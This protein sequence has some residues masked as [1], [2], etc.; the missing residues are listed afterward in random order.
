METLGEYLW[1]KDNFNSYPKPTGIL[2]FNRKNYPNEP[3][4]IFFW[5][6]KTAEKL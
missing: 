5:P 6:E 4:S 3:A 2:C 1:D